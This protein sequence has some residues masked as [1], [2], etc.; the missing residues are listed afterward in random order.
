MD[1][2]V[3]TRMNSYLRIDYT[4]TYSLRMTIATRLD[5]AMSEA[6]FD[7]QSALARASSVPQP[8]INRILKGGGKRGP[9]TQTIIQLANACNVTFEWLHEGREPKRR[10][11]GI[12]PH[13]FTNVVVP[14]PNDPDFYEIPKVQLVLSAGMTSFQT[15]PEIYDGS[16]LSISRNWV[17]RHGYIPERL[18]AIRI[19]GDSMEPNLYEGDQ[20]IINT[21]D[22]KMEDGAVFAFNF[23]GQAVVKR[24]ARDRGEW[25]LTSDNADQV[26]HK[27]KSCRDGECMIIGRIVKRETERI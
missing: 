11:A 24:L 26:R 14:E 22:T 10:T 8:T 7:S 27:R 18:I 13:E 9:E 15:V 3:N 25:W 19:K 17:D 5:E 2:Q 21:A 12:S 23:E 6:G 4:R 16:K 20:V 1:K